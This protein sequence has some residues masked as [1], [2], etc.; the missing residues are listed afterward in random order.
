MIKAIVGSYVFKWR[1]RDFIGYVV[2]LIDELVW[3]VMHE[4]FE[5]LIAGPVILD[6]WTSHRMKMHYGTMK[7]VLHTIGVDTWEVF[8]SIYKT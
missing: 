3:E 6:W 7:I 4:H 2:R 8:N 5:N 1:E